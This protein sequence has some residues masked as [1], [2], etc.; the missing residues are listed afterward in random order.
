MIKHIIDSELKYELD[1][2]YVMVCTLSEDKQEPLRQMEQKKN[3]L[4][5]IDCQVGDASAVCV[6]DHWQNLCILVQC[7]T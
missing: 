7:R 5:V 6:H 1:D 3:E 4:N 2:N